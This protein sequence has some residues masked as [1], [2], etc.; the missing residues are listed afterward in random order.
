M[1]KNR[2]VFYSLAWITSLEECSAHSRCY[3]KGCKLM[4][5]IGT[6]VASIMI[7]C[8]VFL[9]LDKY[10]QVRFVFY[11]LVLYSKSGPF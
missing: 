11:C 8:A 2:D 1:Q 7:F 3:A 10:S 9:D 5:L 4:I 6:R